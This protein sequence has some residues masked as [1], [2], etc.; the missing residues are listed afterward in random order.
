MPDWLSA[1]S[2]R[3]LRSAQGCRQRRPCNARLERRALRRQM[4]RLP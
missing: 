2:D 1:L 4:P 3:S